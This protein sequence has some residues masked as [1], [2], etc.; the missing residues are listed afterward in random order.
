MLSIFE[1]TLSV[2]ICDQFAFYPFRALVAGGIASWS[3][4]D[5]QSSFF[6]RFCFTARSQTHA[7]NV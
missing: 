7:L 2:A 5:R 6:G 3:D 1:S 4:L